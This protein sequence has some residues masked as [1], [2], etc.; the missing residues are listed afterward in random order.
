VS[1]PSKTAETLAN[2][3]RRLSSDHDGEIIA[4]MH[5]IR[6]CWNP[7]AATFTRSLRRSRTAG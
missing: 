7:V 2:V 5:I 6:A 3:V 4:A 1:L